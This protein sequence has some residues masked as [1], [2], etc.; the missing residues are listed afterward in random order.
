MKNFLH[1]FADSV[2]EVGRHLLRYGGIYLISGALL[3]LMSAGVYSCGGYYA[4]A[5]F[6]GG[7]A[8]FAW[9]VIGPSLF[10]DRTPRV[11][12]GPPNPPPP[13]PPRPRAPFIPNPPPPPPSQILN[14]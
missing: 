5:A 3:G 13:A 7:I 11:R 1:H 8:L 4:I 14:P 6:Y 9:A 10:A 12:G 2:P